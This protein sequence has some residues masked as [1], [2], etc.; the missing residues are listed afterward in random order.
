MPN[1]YCVVSLVPLMPNSNYI[2]MDKYRFILEKG[3]KKHHCPGC[4]KKRFVRYVDTRTGNYLPEQYGRCDRESKCS[5]HLNPYLDGHVQAIQERD[6]PL[7][8]SHKWKTPRI[9]TKPQILFKPVYFDFETFKQTLRSERYQCNSFIQNLLYNVAYPFRAEDVTKA[10]ELYRLGTIVK[11]EW[12]GAV[13]FPYIDI[14][15]YV[16]AIQVKLFDKNNHT[17]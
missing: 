15:G 14:N 17:T 13:T 1:H 7:T 5:Y 16:R 10:V 9:E 3:S 11:G 8:V 2:N 4:G 6:I 12:T